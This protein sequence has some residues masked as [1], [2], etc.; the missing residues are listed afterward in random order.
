VWYP[1][2]G[3]LSNI[4]L[5]RYASTFGFDRD[6]SVLELDY[7]RYTE[8][9]DGLI[10]AAQA[11]VAQAGDG[12]PFFMLPYLNF[13]GFPAGQYLNRTALQGQVE[14]RWMFE[15]D[16]GAVG[17]AGAGVVADSFAELGEGSEGYGIGVGL[18][19]RVSDA[20]QMNIGLDVAYGSNDEAA[21][22]F[23]IGEA[24]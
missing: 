4:S 15:K 1:A 18:R 16:F 8:V 7:G 23:R 13:R 17:F 20:D 14:L 24:F 22:Y 19:Y 12:A 5:I 3:A 10:I 6:F 21:V 2:S 11:R 9:T